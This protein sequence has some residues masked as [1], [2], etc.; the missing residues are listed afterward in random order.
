MLCT[1]GEKMLFFFWKRRPYF[2]ILS[3]HF[4]PFV[5]HSWISKG[6]VAYFSYKE[7]ITF[8]DVNHFVPFGIYGIFH[9]ALGPAITWA[10]Y[11][12]ELTHSVPRAYRIWR[13]FAYGKIHVN[14]QQRQWSMSVWLFRSFLSTIQCQFNL[15]NPR[16][17]NQSGCAL[18]STC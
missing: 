3:T 6:K 10:H 17:V 2:R 7:D 11:S 18:C 1:C 15:F 8:A 16:C 13:I 12:N 14:L 4:L 5:L 9:V